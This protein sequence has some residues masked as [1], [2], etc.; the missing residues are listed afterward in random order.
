MV[1][2]HVRSSMERNK[3]FRAMCQDARG[4]LSSGERWLVADKRCRC[5]VSPKKTTYARHKR[6]I[7]A[8]NNTEDAGTRMSGLVDRYIK[9]SIRESGDDCQQ[10]KGTIAGRQ[11]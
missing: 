10:P 1:G 11:A 4:A 9:G 5:C 2:T 3:R 6:G 8:M 7:Q